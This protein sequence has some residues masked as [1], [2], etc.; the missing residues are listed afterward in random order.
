MIVKFKR[1]IEFVK[2]KGYWQ[3]IKKG[4]KQSML[5]PNLFSIN[6]LNRKWEPG[7]SNSCIRPTQ[8]L[9]LKKTFKEAGLLFDEVAYFFILFLIQCLM[10]P[11][12]PLKPS[13]FH[14]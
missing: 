8:S 7:E 6:P 13:C 14:K 9:Q 2:G 4:Q 3:K 5:S 10:P 12:I 11:R 1:L